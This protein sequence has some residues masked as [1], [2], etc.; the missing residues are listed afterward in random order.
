MIQN[1]K[2]FSTH[3]YTHMQTYHVHTHTS[4]GGLHRGPLPDG[5]GE[6]DQG[7]GRPHHQPEEG[8]TW[9][10]RVPL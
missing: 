7:D 8:R 2:F 6:T 1:A 3:V 9:T 5:T 10:W 4:D